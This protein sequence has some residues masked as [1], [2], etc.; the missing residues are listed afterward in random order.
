MTSTFLVLG[1]SQ[2]ATAF[3]TELF[4]A[5]RLQL[6]LIAL[7]PALLFTRIGIRFAQRVS[8]ETFNTILLI[9]FSLMEVKLVIDI[10]RA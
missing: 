6:G 2:T 9:T 8:Q 1:I 4:T 3:A 10:I 7:V 5:E